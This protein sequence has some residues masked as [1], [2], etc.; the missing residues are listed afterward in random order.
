MQSTFVDEFRLLKEIG[1]SIQYLPVS[2]LKSAADLIPDLDVEGLID[3]LHAAFPDIRVDPA[4]LAQ[5]ARC[6]LALCRL[7][8]THQL[9]LI[10][11][12]DVD[13]GLHEAFGL[14]PCLYSAALK[15]TGVLVGLEGDLGAAIAMLAQQI[16]TGGPLFFVEIWYWDEGENL[17]VGGHAG[18]QDPAAANP[19]T[20]LIGPDLEYAQSDP[21]P[22]AHPLFVAR[23]GIVTLLQVRGTPTGWQAIAATGQALETDAWL[24]GYPHAVIR[25]DAAH[26]RVL[27]AGG[28]GRLNSALGAGVRGYAA[29]NRALCALLAIPLEEISSD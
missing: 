12:N 21:Y 7:A 20:A 23:P 19:A 13:P 26:P 1:P 15:E 3:E 10:S 24:E 5:A 9:D 27:A 25:L 11:I 18:L 4:T 22:G 28:V 17:V 6:S 14:R 8:R 29:G 2:A 16:F